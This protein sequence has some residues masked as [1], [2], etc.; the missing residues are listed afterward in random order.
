MA[1]LSGV[2]ITNNPENQTVCVGGKAVVN[3][4]YTGGSLGLLPALVVNQTIN[5]RDFPDIPGLPSE[6][7]VSS[8]DTATNR[9]IIGPVGERY[10]GMANISCLYQGFSESVHATPA[11]LTVIG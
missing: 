1:L 9:I 5:L 7:I 2:T 6:F 11:V 4:G 8:N 3:C 10:I